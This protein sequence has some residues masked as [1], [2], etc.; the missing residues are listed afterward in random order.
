MRSRPGQFLAAFLALW[1]PFCCCQV[2]AAAAAVAHVAH[3]A[4]IAAANDH[5]PACCREASSG[6]GSDAD[7]HDGCCDEQGGDDH[8]APAKGSCCVSCKERLLPPAVQGDLLPAMS[9]DFVATAVLADGWA[10]QAGAVACPEARA[11]RGPPPTPGGR[12][13]LALHSVLVI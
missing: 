3:V 4:G 7:G 12:A 9:I 8:G 10:A 1:M 13:A 5:R 11:D 2:R 6:G